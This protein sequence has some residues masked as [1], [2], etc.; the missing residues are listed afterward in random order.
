VA[1]K[2]RN[3]ADGRSRVSGKSQAQKLND[4]RDTANEPEEQVSWRN[5]YRVHAA[6]E[7]VANRAP[8]GRRRR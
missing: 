7:A 5:K 6:A 8:S 1:C 4:P 3:P 2:K